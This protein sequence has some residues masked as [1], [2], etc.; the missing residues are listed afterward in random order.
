MHDVSVFEYKD[1]HFVWIITHE[2]VSFNNFVYV[3]VITS[4]ILTLSD[5][6]TTCF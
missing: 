4:M 3:F 6:P 1:K 5:S 2:G